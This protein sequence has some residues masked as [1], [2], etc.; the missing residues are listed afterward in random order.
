MVYAKGFI[1]PNLFGTMV[2]KKQNT[3]PWFDEYLTD[4]KASV[5]MDDVKS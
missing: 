2:K 4:I 1:G 3:R 5:T